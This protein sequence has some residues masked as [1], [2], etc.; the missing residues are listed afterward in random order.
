LVIAIGVGSGIFILLFVLVAVI[1]R[2]KVRDRKP[3]KM[4]EFF[5]KQNRGLLLR[6]LVDKDIAERMIFSLEELEKATNSFDEARKLG[7]GG[8][9]TVYKGILSDQRIVAIKKSRHAIKRE[10]DDFINEV[11]ILSQVN[12]RNVVKLFG[13]CLETEVPLLV[14]EFIS[15]GTLH[16]HLHV[17]PPSL[18]WK[19]RMRIALKIVR[20]LAYLHSAASV[21]VIHRDIKNTNILLDD[22]FIAKVSDFVASRGIPIDPTAVMTTIQGTFGYLDPEHYQ[23]SRLTEKSDV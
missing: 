5:F 16:H 13:C 7:G 19:Q 11:A 2:T 20:S 10:I 3:T 4:K 1:I 6:Q 21:S 17:A 14:Y 18:S 15:N 8:H 22:Q 12:H 23:T 9:G